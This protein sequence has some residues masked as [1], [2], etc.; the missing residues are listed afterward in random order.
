VN[1]G[2]DDLSKAFMDPDFPHDERST[3][4]ERL[5]IS[6]MMGTGDLMDMEKGGAS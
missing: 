6:G 4:N 3:K 2:E 5:G 1:N